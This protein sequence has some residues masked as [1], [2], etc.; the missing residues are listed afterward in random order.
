MATR[1]AE[2]LN[3]WPTAGLA[4]GVVR[5]GSPAWFRGHGVA[6]IGSGTP[7]DEDTVFRIAS[8]SKTITAIAVMQLWEQGLVDL[9]APANDYLRGYSLVPAKAGFRPATLRHLLTHTAGVRA[10]RRPSDLLRPALGWGARVGRP[11]PSLAEYYRG[12]L[13]VDFEPGTKWAY[14]NHGFATLGQIVEDVSGLPLD[15]YLRERV[16]GPLGME[17]SDL[18]RSERVRPRLATGYAL[19]SRGLKAV[20]DREMAI[21][22]AGS[23]YS[24]TSDMARYVSALLGGGA[25][26]RGSVLRPETLARMFEPHYQP[27]PRIPGMGWGSFATRPADTGPSVTTAS[28]RASSPTSCSL[29]TRGSVSSRSP[30]PEGSTAAARRCRSRTRCSVTSSTSRTKQCAPM[31]RSS[32]G[33][34]VTCAAGTRSVP[35]CSPTPSPERCSGLAPR[36]SSAAGSSRFADRHRSRRCAR[37]FASTLTATTPTPSASISP[38]S[39]WAPLLSCSAATPTAR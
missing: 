27:D 2:V 35:A 32:P 3:R 18:V 5:D 33:S 37:A 25:N 26:E 36:S 30:T 23:V 4:V 7:V 10:V 12:G 1:V 9:D 20:A 29:P 8:I 22:G 17:N 15:R 6:E 38:G 13:R 21:A 14:S 39:A 11:A 34:G 28:G 24:T 16:F 31:S 19:R